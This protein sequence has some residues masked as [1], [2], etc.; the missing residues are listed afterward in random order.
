MY[1]F[2]GNNSV[3]DSQQFLKSKANTGVNDDNIPTTKTFHVSQIIQIEKSL[4]NSTHFKIKFVRSHGPKWYYFETLSSSDR[5]EI[6]TKLS[7]LKAIYNRN[8]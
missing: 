4:K 3:W 7:M 1:G 5:N 8:K 6:I 2:G